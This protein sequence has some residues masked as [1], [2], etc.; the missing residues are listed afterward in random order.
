M[1]RRDLGAN[2]KAA[3]RD[4]TRE[5]PRQEDF[6]SHVGDSTDPGL[7]RGSEAPGLQHLKRH[8]FSGAA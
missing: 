4:R 7:G 5:G 6:D 3:H 1:L 2:S 8:P